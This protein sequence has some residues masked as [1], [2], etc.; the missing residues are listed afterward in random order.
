MKCAKCVVRYSTVPALLRRTAR[1][2]RLAGV[3]RLDD[4]RAAE[5]VRLTALLS[6]GVQHQ[7]GGEHGD[8]EEEV[9]QDGDRRVHGEGLQHCGNV[10]TQRELSSRYSQF[11]VDCIYR[12]VQS[13]FVTAKQYIHCTYGTCCM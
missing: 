8:L 11:I 3:L 7:D 13:S 10:R 4:P 1:F 5:D 2:A 9:K 6:P 12:A